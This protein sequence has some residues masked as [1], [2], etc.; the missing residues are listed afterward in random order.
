LDDANSIINTNKL[1]EFPINLNTF[2]FFFKNYE[3]PSN[4]NSSKMTIK[5]RRLSVS[6]FLKVSPEEDDENSKPN[7]KIRSSFINTNDIDEEMSKDDI[8]N[9]KQANDNS[10]NHLNFETMTNS[11]PNKPT[12]SLSYYFRKCLLFDNFLIHNFNGK[13]EIYYKHDLKSKLDI[14]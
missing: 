14:E 10:K 2:R 7:K 13:L 4:I 3:N 1:Q 12:N 8:A 9:I 5:E 11:D 6:Q